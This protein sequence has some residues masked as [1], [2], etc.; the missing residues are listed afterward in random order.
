[1][2]P[3][4]VKLRAQLEPLYVKYSVNAVFAGHSHCYERTKPQQGVQYFTEGA[5]GEIKKRTLDRKSPYLAA[6]EDS[7]NSFLLV[8]AT[9][10]EMKVD[11]IAADGKLL[12]SYTMKRK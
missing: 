9:E 6:G 4:Y 8:Q 11:A 2:H 1:M 5:S 7:V 10:D 12:D 3:P